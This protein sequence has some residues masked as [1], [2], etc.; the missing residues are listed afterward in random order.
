[1]RIGEVQQLTTEW[2]QPL[3]KSGLYFVS[4]G[5][6]FK[7][8]NLNTFVN[9]EIVGQARV[10]ELA[11]YGGWPK[12]QRP[13]PKRTRSTVQHSSSGLAVRPNKRLQS[14]KARRSAKKNAKE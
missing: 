6:G 12:S 5:G 3:V 8:R 9:G 14:T 4:L 1:M 2:Y 11:G 13:R 10:E 7:D